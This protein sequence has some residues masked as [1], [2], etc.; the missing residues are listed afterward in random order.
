MSDASSTITI[1]GTSQKI[2]KKVAIL[3]GVAVVVGFLL[4]RNKQGPTEPAE[5][6]Q[7]GEGDLGEAGASGGISDNATLDAILAALNNLSNLGPIYTP[8]P[9]P[10]YTLGG[11]SS[12][13]LW[14]GPSQDGVGS[15]E[16]TGYRGIDVF[17][18]EGRPV[19]G[20]RTVPDEAPVARLDRHVSAAEQRRL[21]DE[22][23]A[24]SGSA[25]AATAYVGQTAQGYMQQ[26]SRQV[27]QVGNVSSGTAYTGHTAAGFMATLARQTSQTPQF[28]RA[29]PVRRAVIV[30]KYTPPSKPVYKPP[31]RP[32]YSSPAVRRE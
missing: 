14:S 8:A 22:R 30:K 29:E 9:A 16:I 1:P 26:L 11:W 17:G 6:P 31:P 13:G 28:H 25:T 12:E 5:E 4:L 19:I 15:T 18:P 23:R 3:G 20:R 10:A 32:S 24:T 2:P 21:A 27:A 7:Y